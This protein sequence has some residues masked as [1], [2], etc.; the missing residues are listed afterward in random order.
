MQARPAPS[1]G[2]PSNP[3]KLRIESRHL[4]LDGA[5]RRR[6]EHRVRLAL[7][8]HG[9]RIERARVTLSPVC[10]DRPEGRKRCRIWVRLLEDAS[11]VAEREA[12]DLA[13]ATDRASWW[14]EHRLD[15]LR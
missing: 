15:R 6:I 13:L 1:P 12:T 8:R 5:L 14:M 11:L 10:R 9:A 2:P 7:G 4:R 3:V